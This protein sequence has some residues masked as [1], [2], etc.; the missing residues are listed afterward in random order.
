MVITPFILI[1][2][3]EQLLLIPLA[4]LRLWLLVVVDLVEPM[5]PMEVEAVVVREDT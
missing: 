3:L 5:L 1:Q 4:L 2:D